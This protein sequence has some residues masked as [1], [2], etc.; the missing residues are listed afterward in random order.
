MELDNTYSYKP[1]YDPFENVKTRNG[2]P[3]DEVISSLQKSIRHADEAT[4]VRC[5]YE[6]YCTSQEMEIYL[7][8]RLSVICVEDIGFGEPT[9]P[10]LIN[11]LKQLRLDFPYTLTGSRALFPIHAV[12]YLC[13]C[14]KERS[15]DTLKTIILEEYKRGQY[16]KIPTE[17]DIHD[18]HTK[19]GKE[20]GKTYLDF[21]ETYT[22]V[23]PFMDKYDPELKELLK[24]YTKEDIEAGQE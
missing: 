2:L 10:I 5:A 8:R 3:A 17:Y 16:A 7:W 20:A 4:A 15:S 12:R 13:K 21:L 6:M 23:V 18:W 19:A 14:Q 24:K 9:A 22:D 11:T 1:S